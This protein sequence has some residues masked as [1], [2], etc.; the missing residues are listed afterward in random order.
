ME[1][2]IR[3]HGLDSIADEHISFA[4]IFSRYLD[5]WIISRQEGKTTWEVQGGHRDEN[6]VIRFTAARELYEE[7]G[8]RVF[9]IT[10]YF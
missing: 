10:P 8:A 7:S 3:N 4:V 5:Q 6:E 1:I 2:R 9:R